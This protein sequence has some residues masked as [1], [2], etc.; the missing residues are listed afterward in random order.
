MKASALIEDLQQL[1]QEC[2]DLEVVNDEDEAIM[3]NYDEGEEGEREPA[4]V[5][6]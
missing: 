4:F 5:I 6:S 2:G 1:I 3:V